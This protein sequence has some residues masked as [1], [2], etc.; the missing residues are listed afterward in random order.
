LSEAFVGSEFEILCRG[1]EFICLNNSYEVSF[2]TEIK[3][4]DNQT[5]SSPPAETTCASGAESFL[6]K[7]LQGG[8]RLP[9]K[10]AKGARHIEQM[11]AHGFC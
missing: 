10:R 7:L 5:S 11:V 1:W 4:A 8:T 2:G 3:D 9:L 6:M